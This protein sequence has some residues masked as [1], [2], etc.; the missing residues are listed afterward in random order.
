MVVAIEHVRLLHLSFL[1]NFSKK[2]EQPEIDNKTKFFGTKGRNRWWTQAVV[3]AVDQAV[4]PS[5]NNPSGG[6]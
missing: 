1:P 6:G 5:Y 3:D 4:D 2:N